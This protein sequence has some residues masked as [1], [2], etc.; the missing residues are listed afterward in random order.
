M[1]TFLKISVFFLLLNISSN[2]LLAEGEWESIGHEGYD[3][4]NAA[5]ELDN[6]IPP[7]IKND[8]FYKAIYSLARTADIYTILEIGSSSGEGS[9]EAFVTGMRENPNHP[10]L[11]CMEVSETRFS[12]LQKH[13]AKEVREGSVLCYNVSSVPLRDFPK[14]EVVTSFYNLTPTNLN[15][16]PL[17]MVL[18]WLRR[19]IDYIKAHP[20]PQNG[21]E[22]IKNINRIRKF[23]MVLIDGCE[24]TGMAEMK[25]IYGANYILLDDINTFKNFTNY[26]NLCADKSYELLEANPYVRNGYAIFKRK[27]Y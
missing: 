27:K 16:F 2:H 9:T 13:Y 4:E 24:F 26:K 14:E 20:V 19:D 3:F 1:K 21:I 17:E 8:P 22:I 6:L 10:R 18:G 12:A 23:G 15:F 25:Y 5:S 11:F 7:E